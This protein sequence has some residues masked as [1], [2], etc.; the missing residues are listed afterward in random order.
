MPERRSLPNNPVRA[1]AFSFRLAA[2]SRSFPRFPRRRFSKDT[3]AL[4]FFGFTFGRD[5]VI[6]EIV[7]VETFSQEMAE[8]TKAYDMH[9]IC[10]EKTPEEFQGTLISLL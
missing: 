3:G 4:C 10:L 5:A 6:R 8:A 1:P 9:V 2:A 7:T